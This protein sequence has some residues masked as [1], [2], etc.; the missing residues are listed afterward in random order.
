[1]REMA[2]GAGFLIETQ[3]HVRR[4]PSGFLLPAI[5]TLARRP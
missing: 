2:T 3:Q 5:L 4:L 1:M